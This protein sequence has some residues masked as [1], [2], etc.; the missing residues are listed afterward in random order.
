MTPEISIIVPQFEKADLTIRCIE[1]LLKH[2]SSP[3]QIILVDDGSSKAALRS[4]QQRQFSNTEVV[5]NSENR[6]ITYSW[7]RGA[8][9][10]QGVFLI[11][12]NNDV[13]THG[14]WCER[15]IAPI[16]KSE[17]LISGPKSRVESRFPQHLDSTSPKRKLLE[18]WCLALAKSY[19]DRLGQFDERYRLYFSDTDLQL[20]ILQSFESRERSSQQ[21]LR[22]VQEVPGLPVEHL[23]HRTTRSQP[24]RS[25][26]WRRDRKTYLQQWFSKAD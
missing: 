5:R 12:L 2:H 13:E 1:S 25:R 14:D 19:F 6:G 3:M 17:C 8:E 18:G 20:R 23:G 21:V 9:L 15:L 10:A 22:G 24:S 26:Q 4:I 7:N 11:F 16:R